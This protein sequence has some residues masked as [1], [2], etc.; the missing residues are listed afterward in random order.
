MPLIPAK[1]R[2]KVIE[3][4]KR[5]T[6][7]NSVVYYEHR[8]VTPFG[9]IRW[10]QWSNR[11]ILDKNGKLTEYQAVGRDITERKV[12]EEAVKISEDRFR[13]VANNAHE[14]IWETDS[15]GRYTFSNQIV[16]EILGY[17]ADDVVGKKFVYD[18]INSAKKEKIW[19]NK[20]KR[21]R[22]EYNKF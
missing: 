20:N 22:C 19:K 17:S 11:G 13:Q 1:D 8:V 7:E 16:S 10:Q 5:V 3:N 12:A 6:K 18:M 15:E 9:E 14:W 2:H 21:S 4:H